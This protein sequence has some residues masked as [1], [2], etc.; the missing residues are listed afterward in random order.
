MQFAACY[1]GGPAGPCVLSGLW[2]LALYFNG[3]GENGVQL[4]VRT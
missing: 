2:L 4:Y 1:R 3:L